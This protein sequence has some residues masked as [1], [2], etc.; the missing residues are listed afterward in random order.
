M[1]KTINYTIN[2]QIT[3]QTNGESTGI[4]L[5]NVFTNEYGEEIPPTRVAKFKTSLYNEN[6]LPLE[7]FICY[8]DWMTRSGLTTEMYSF[9]T[10]EPF[11]GLRVLY[12]GFPLM[13]SGS[14]CLHTKLPLKDLNKYQMQDCYLL[15][16]LRLFSI[17]HNSRPKLAVS[18]SSTPKLPKI[19]VN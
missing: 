3:V 8:Q 7:V 1:K 2:D 13:V 17:L 10:T 5:A 15:L 6:K 16:K 11:I 4:I 19:T 18:K 14:V 12:N 9:N